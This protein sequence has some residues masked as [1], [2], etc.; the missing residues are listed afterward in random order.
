MEK[1]MVWEDE[2]KGVIVDEIIGANERS[3]G[4]SKCA[5]YRVKE[6]MGA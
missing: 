1:S 4:L 6:G 5:R 2:R 3:D